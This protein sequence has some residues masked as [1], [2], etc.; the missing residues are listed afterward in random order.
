MTACGRLIQ[1]DGRKGL[2]GTAILANGT[3]AGSGRQQQRMK[4]TG[5]M[6]FSPVPR[7]KAR[8]GDKT[9]A[10]LLAPDSQQS[11][12]RIGR[13]G[14]AGLATGRKRR[15]SKYPATTQWAW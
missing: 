1:T 13:A 4:G 9:K 8:P 6:N 15:R 2:G 14:Q 12:P 11:I 3:Q 10:P 5:R 7:E